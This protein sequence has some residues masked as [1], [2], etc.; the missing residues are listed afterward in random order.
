MSDRTFKIDQVPE[1]N[2]DHEIQLKEINEIPCTRAEVSNIGSRSGYQ[3]PSQK[4]SIKSEKS[5]S[6]KKST[7][8]A[9]STLASSSTNP[10]IIDESSDAQ[11]SRKTV[12]KDESKRETITSLEKMASKLQVSNVLVINS[13]ITLF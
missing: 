7:V 2:F 6:L 10:L 3:V 4:A 12:D 11:V 8:S 1:L 9:K 13:K 5:S